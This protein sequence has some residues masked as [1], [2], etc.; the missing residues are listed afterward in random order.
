MDE[1]KV[2]GTLTNLCSTFFS[3]DTVVVAPLYGRTQRDFDP[4]GKPSGHTW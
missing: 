3:S 2:D 1:L 4:S